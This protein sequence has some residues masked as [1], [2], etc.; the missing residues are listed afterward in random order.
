MAYSTRRRPDITLARLAL[1]W[2]PRTPLHEGLQR[3]AKWFEQ[4]LSEAEPVLEL[5][6]SRA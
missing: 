2:E 6:N 5:R 1:G 4:L 3:T